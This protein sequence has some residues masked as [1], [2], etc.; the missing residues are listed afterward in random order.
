MN[1]TLNDLCEIKHFVLQTRVELSQAIESYI[2]HITHILHHIATVLTKV[3]S[4]V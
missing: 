4:C 1:N 3:T 2:K